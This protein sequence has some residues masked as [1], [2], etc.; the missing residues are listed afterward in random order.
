MPVEMQIIRA[1]EFVRL[2]PDE[3]LDF[4]ATR[5]ALEILALASRKRGLDRAVMDLRKWPVMAKPRFTTK[6]LAALV[7]AFREAG[8]PRKH[9]LA[10]LY[11]HDVYGGVRTF[12]FFSRMRGLDVQTFTDF[13]SALQWLSEGHESRDEREHGEVPI[14]IAK[15]QPEAKKGAIRVGSDGRCRTVAGSLHN[16]PRQKAARAHI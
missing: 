13:E 2:D 16:A 3:N 9:R 12:A 14:S 10:I 5:K 6:E 8:L 11:Q 7:S 4:A 1:S 15:P